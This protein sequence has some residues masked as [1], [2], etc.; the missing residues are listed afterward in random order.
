MTSEGTA[1]PS[2]HGRHSRAR[3]QPS[4]APAAAPGHSKPR[5]PGALPTHWPTASFSSIRLLIRCGPND[6]PDE[7]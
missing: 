7:A 4:Q 3:Y 6:Q 1:I 5:D 2:M